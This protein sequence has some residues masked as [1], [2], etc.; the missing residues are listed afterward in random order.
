MHST[1]TVIPKQLQRSELAE[2]GLKNRRWDRKSPWMGRVHNLPTN[3][4]L[5]G[6]RPLCSN[7]GSY[8]ERK[9]CIGS[10]ILFQ[11]NTARLTDTSQ[12]LNLDRVGKS[13]EKYGLSVSVIGAADSMTGTA[14]VNNVSSASRADYIAEELIK[15]RVSGD[16][17]NK[18]HQGGI[19]D[20]APNGP[21]AIQRLCCISNN[22]FCSYDIKTFFSFMESLSVKIGSLLNKI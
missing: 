17:I 13:S 12:T 3:S 21:T 4:P 11:L 18:T 7:V 16:K 19:S 9:E 5:C 15:R 10:P 2:A 8:A 1:A 14:S 20:Y 6:S 22:T